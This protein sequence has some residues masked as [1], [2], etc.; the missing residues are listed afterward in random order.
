MPPSW[1]VAEY[2]SS[3]LLIPQLVFPHIHQK[4]FLLLFVNVHLLLRDRA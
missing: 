4:S 1:L 3:K 2:G